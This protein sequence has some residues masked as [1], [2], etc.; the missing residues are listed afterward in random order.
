MLRTAH[1]GR[2]LTAP[3]EAGETVRQAVCK[4]APEQ[5]WALAPLEDGGYAVLS[6]LR[7]TC[8]EARAES[9]AD[10]IPIVEAPCDGGPAQSFVVEQGPSGMELRA[11]HSDKCLDVARA[12]QRDGAALIQYTCHAG[13]NQRFTLTST[14]RPPARPPVPACGLCDPA[15]V[16]HVEDDCGKR[17]SNVDEPCSLSCQ[18]QVAC[19]PVD[20]IRTTN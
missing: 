11:R 18:S 13:P 5:R 2:C 17:C 1:S 7:G 6:T 9:R 4:D 15:D 10:E 19:I 3:A 12:S 14:V 16:C 20:D 8:L